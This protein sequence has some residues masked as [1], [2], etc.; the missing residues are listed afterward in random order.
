M[1][2]LIWWFVCLGW[3]LPGPAAARS[4]SDPKLSPAQQRALYQAQEAMAEE[5]NYGQARKPLLDYLKAHP[6]QPHHLIY[7]V[8]GLT[9]H[10][11]GNLARADEAYGRALDLKPDHQPSCLNLAAV[12]Y[13]RQRPGQAARLWE[14]AYHLAD[15]PDPQVLYQAAAAYYQAQ[16]HGQAARVLK[17]L[18]A[19]RGQ[20]PKEWLQ[21]WIH[22]LYELEDLKETERVLTRFVE[23]FPGEADYW[24]L[25]AQVRFR[26]KRH[27][28]AAAALEVAY[29]LKPPQAGAWKNLADVYFYLNVPLR[30][31]RALQKAYG[32]RPSAQE[33]D[34]LAQWLV[35]A[36]RLE[37]ALSYLDLALRK[38]P[39]A[40]R[41]LE[42]GRLLYQN[43]RY[44]RAVAALQAAVSLEPDLY[45]A[46]LLLGLSALEIE[47]IPLAQ[48]ALTAAARS[49]KHRNQAQAAL[50]LVA[51]QETQ[52]QTGPEQKEL[53]D[54]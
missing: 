24:R 47:M 21:L 54:N 38:E 12:R 33:C 43:G 10:Q 14:K 17:D 11:E 37:E 45:S 4:G 16:E 41:H 49:D 40:Q 48:K 36:G 26:Q 53:T 22:V 32:P 31:V 1:K 28:A 44:G 18:L 8:L 2:I 9:W 20:P 27:R 30:G 46:Q 35:R 19:G 7:Y 51:D 15:Q 39:T 13:E 50:L 3:L 52:A 23:R 42:K 25:L 34:Q 5:K 6:D 29:A